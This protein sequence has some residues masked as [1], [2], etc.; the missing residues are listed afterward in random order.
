[1]CVCV[2][3]SRPTSAITPRDKPIT[4]TEL[5]SLIDSIQDMETIDEI[6][7][8]LTDYTSEHAHHLFT[9]ENITN[10]ILANTHTDTHS[11][12]DRLAI[13]ELVGPKLCID[14]HTQTHSSGTDD[15]SHRAQFE[16]S[17]EYVGL[18]ALF[19]YSAE[20]QEHVRVL[21]GG[22]IITLSLEVEAAK[23]VHTRND[24]SF[25]QKLIQSIHSNTHTPTHTPPRS[26]S[27]TPA[28]NEDGEQTIIDSSN[29]GKLV[30]AVDGDAALMVSAST[31]KKVLTLLDDDIDDLV[32]GPI[33]AALLEDDAKSNIADTHSD[34]HSDIHSDAYSDAQSDVHTDASDVEGDTGATDA[35]S[36]ELSFPALKQPKGNNA[37]NT[38]D[39]SQQMG[40]HKK[41]RH[42]KNKHN[43]RRNSGGNSNNNNTKITDGEHKDNDNNENNEESKGPTT[44]LNQLVVDEHDAEYEEV[45]RR[46]EQDEDDYFEHMNDDSYAEL[47][48]S[49]SVPGSAAA[50][51]A[52]AALNMSVYSSNSSDLSGILTDEYTD[53]GAG[54]AN[55]EHHQQLVERMLS[56]D[57]NSDELVTLESIVQ[58]A[59]NNIVRANKSIVY[60]DGEDEDEELKL[61]D[62]PVDGMHARHHTSAP[63]SSSAPGHSQIV[64][65]LER[66]K[67]ELL[68]ALGAAIL[69][70]E[71]T[72]QSSFETKQ[73]LE[74]QI[75]ALTQEIDVFS[76][77]KE[78][79]V[80]DYE[81]QIHDL[82]QQLAAQQNEYKMK[83]FSYQSELQELKHQLDN[84]MRD[85]ESLFLQHKQELESLQHDLEVTVSER[86]LMAIE[87]L[88][89]LQSKPST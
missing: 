82:E 37:H 48:L 19:D 61:D 75:E 72:V 76:A 22:R 44:N 79:L 86:E 21:M 74:Q 69:A 55:V 64:S 10:L 25:S 27:T 42:K 78:Q 41:S 54:V 58:D 73:E 39:S 66:E 85:K 70:K 83:M 28:L 7:S 6:T 11:T 60:H 80:S 67:Q 15:I 71:H 29:S 20:D 13:M 65:C 36:R 43:N 4:E 81:A 47:L 24:A 88:Q 14:I 17:P 18:L 30:S 84:A 12:T 56:T 26:Q 1:M 5:S 23:A 16:S 46:L 52:V 40:K 59:I 68:S 34:V 53:I 3:S 8:Y 49:H 35:T 2:Q 50:A 87:Y 77:E 89:L 63:T 32:I 45:R 51:A 38:N 57:S 62:E 33:D 31:Q 9:I